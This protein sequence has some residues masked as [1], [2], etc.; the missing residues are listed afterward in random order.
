MP[1]LESKLGVSSARPRSRAARRIASASGCSLPWSRLAARRSSSSAD[2]VRRGHSASNAGFPS[3]SVPVLS[4]TSVST[5]RRFSIAAASRNRMPRVAPRPDATMIDIGVARPSAHGHAMISTVTALMSPNI[6]LGS[7]PSQ[8]Q[9]RTS[10]RDRDH[11]R[12]RNARDA[13]G[14]AL[15]RRLRALRLRHERTICASTVWEPT[16]SDAHPSE[17]V[18]F[19]VAPISGR[20]VASS[21]AAARP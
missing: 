20:R 11:E 7:G 19:S 6:Q 15:H 2:N 5:R 16:R 12:P 8:P 4:T 17:P 21:R 3:V 14:H 10:Q 9:A 1:E 18:V 13:V